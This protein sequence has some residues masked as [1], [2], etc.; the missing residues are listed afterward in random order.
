LLETFQTFPNETVIEPIIKESSEDLSVEAKCAFLI[1]RALS[2]EA[3]HCKS[4]DE[5]FRVLACLFSQG[6]LRFSPREVVTDGEKPRV[7]DAAT[8]IV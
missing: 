6:V 2:P 1:L 7:T 5:V 8:V 3:Y 4:R